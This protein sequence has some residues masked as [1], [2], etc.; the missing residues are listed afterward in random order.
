MKKS[1]LLIGALLGLFT[2]LLGSILFIL[3]FT[4]YGIFDGLQFILASGKMGKLLTLGALL[5][6]LLFFALLKKNKELMARGIVLGSI[7][8]TVLTLLL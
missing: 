8:L 4:T 3:L 5:N 6:L 2:S 7:V 1:D